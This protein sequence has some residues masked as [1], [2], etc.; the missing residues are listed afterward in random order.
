MHGQ[1]WHHAAT[2]AAVDDDDGITA[3]MH[4]PHRE[5]SASG[6]IATRMR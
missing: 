4:A 6:D 1:H 2:A 5:M 3:I